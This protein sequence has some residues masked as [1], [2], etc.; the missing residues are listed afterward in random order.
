MHLVASLLVVSAVFVALSF[1]TRYH[2]SSVR[3]RF[4][5]S[6]EFG[7]T[8]KLLDLTGID[9]M[10]LPLEAPNAKYERV[11]TLP[12]LTISMG[13]GT[14]IVTSVPSD[15]PDDY[16]SLKMLVDKPEWAEKYGITKVS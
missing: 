8:K 7:V 1:L 10:G 16:V 12:L 3:C 11:Y 15:A 13:K 5:S 9:L 14:G 4:F 6:Q 2:Q